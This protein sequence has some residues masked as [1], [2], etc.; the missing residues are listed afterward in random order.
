MVSPSLSF[1]L[2][3]FPT[4]LTGVGAHNFTGRGKP[5]L[6]LSCLAREARAVKVATRCFQ[7]SAKAQPRRTRFGV[8][9]RVYIPYVF[10]PVLFVCLFRNCVACACVFESCSSET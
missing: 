8:R 9:V 3:N 1:S 7:C 10:S 5:E 6:A 4:E 2:V